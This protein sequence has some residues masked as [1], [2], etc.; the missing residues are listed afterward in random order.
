M[1][2]VVTMRHLISF[3]T[4]IWLVPLIAG[5]CKGS[6]EKEGRRKGAAVAHKLLRKQ[7]KHQR[8]LQTEG[9][10]GYYSEESFQGKNAQNMT[11]EHYYEYDQND[12]TIINGT[13]YNRSDVES[14]NDKS[15]EEEYYNNDNNEEN[16]H[17]GSSQNTTEGNYYEYEQNNS[18]NNGS[19]NNSGDDENNNDMSD[20]G[21]YYDNDNN[22]GENDSGSNVDYSSSDG[23]NNNSGN[24]GGGNYGTNAGYYD[25]GYYDAENSYTDMLKKYFAS[26]AQDGYQSTPISW[27]L[28]QWVFF[29]VI[30]FLFGITF[31]LCCVT[32]VVPFYCPGL[33]RTYARTFLRR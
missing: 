26:H 9:G 16:Y 3:V 29:A 27:D 24:N 17:D 2:D 4:S 28:E 14:S 6:D 15:D 12:G 30:M 5:S 31:T 23:G 32:M 13:Y 22:G 10:S 25:A 8:S 11:E 7:Y 18:G 19:N 20:E 1:N 33:M 21:G